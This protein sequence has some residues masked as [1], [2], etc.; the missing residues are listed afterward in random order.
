MSLKPPLVLGAMSFEELIAV[1]NWMCGSSGAGGQKAKPFFS[2]GIGCCFGAQ[3][4]TISTKKIA[5][6]VIGRIM[7]HLVPATAEVKR[8][9]TGRSV[10]KSRMADSARAA[11]GSSSV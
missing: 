7:K 5:K 11:G 8:L 3:P 9:G 10:I 2:T 6:I 1:R 4:V